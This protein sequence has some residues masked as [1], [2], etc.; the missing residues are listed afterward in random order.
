MHADVASVAGK[1]GPAFRGSYED[2]TADDEYGEFRVNTRLGHAG[3]DRHKKF[4]ESHIG[5]VS[6]RFREHGLDQLGVIGDEPSNFPMFT[7]TLA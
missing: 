2:F 4:L 1:S 7:R 3:M 5:A 6:A